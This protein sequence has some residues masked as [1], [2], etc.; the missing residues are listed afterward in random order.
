MSEVLCG[1]C[2]LH[3]AASDLWMF[4]HSNLCSELE[5]CAGEFPLRCE[6]LPRN[7]LSDGALCKE[8]SALGIAMTKI[9]YIFNN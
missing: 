5:N 8:I 6:L 1:A 7:L 9:I 4:H 2:A 3:R